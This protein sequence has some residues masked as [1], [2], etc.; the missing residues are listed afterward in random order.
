MSFWAKRWITEEKFNDL[1]RSTPSLIKLETKWSEGS[2]PILLVRAGH[3][4]DLP[5]KPEHE[6]CYWYQYPSKAR[7][8]GCKHAEVCPQYKS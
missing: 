3:E 5:P 8:S 4:S 7:C 2:S 6:K 1:C